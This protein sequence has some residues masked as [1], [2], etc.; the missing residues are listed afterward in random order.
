MKAPEQT[1]EIRVVFDLPFPLY[2][3]DTARKGQSATIR[4]EIYVAGNPPAGI[5]IL[6]EMKAG[7]SGMATLLELDGGDRFGRYSSSSLQVRFSLRDSPELRH[8]EHDEMVRIAVKSVNRLISHYRDLRDQPM[9][10]GLIPADIGHFSVQYNNERTLIHSLPYATG[11]G[12]AVGRSHDELERFDQNL[13]ARLQVDSRPKIYR[14]LELRMNRLFLETDYRG[15]V[16][17]AAVLVESWMKAYVREQFEK[18][19]RTRDEIESAMRDPRG[20]PVTAHHVAT[21]LI[22]DSTGVDFEH[23]NEFRP[24]RNKVAD[25]RN[26]LVHGTRHDVTEFEA[27]EALD[28]VH[29]TIAVLRRSAP[30]GTAL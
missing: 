19:G 3:L 8:A 22:K 26:D 21:V 1:T 24:W 23:G 29:A 18:R 5:H 6:R 14:E 4:E 28:S 27:K 2:L 7:I 17:E 13:R 30:N 12:P 9:I 16:I 11:L 10:E 15:C 25:V 20:R